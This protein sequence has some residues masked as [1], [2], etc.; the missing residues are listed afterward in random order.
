VTVGWY[1]IDFNY[2]TFCVNGSKTTQALSLN[3]NDGIVGSYADSSGTHG[4]LIPALTSSDMSVTPIDV[5]IGGTNYYNGLVNS[6]NT[7]WAISG[8]YDD[9]AGNSYGFLGT[10]NPCPNSRPPRPPRGDGA[11]R[12]PRR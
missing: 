4:F 6:L 8:Q 7:E 12:G 11:S 5:M 2:Q 3:D 1:Y 10:C 9:G